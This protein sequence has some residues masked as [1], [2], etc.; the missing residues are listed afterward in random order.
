MKIFDIL[1]LITYYSVIFPSKL[2]ESNHPDA[3]RTIAERPN[4]PNNDWT[5][6]TTMRLR[7]SSRDRTVL[8][9]RSALK[10][11]EEKRKGRE[12]E[13][14][15]GGTVLHWK[16]NSPSAVAWCPR[17]PSAWRIEPPTRRLRA[18][19]VNWTEISTV[20]RLPDPQDPSAETSS[21][22]SLFFY[23]PREYPIIFY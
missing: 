3:T 18:T 19:H 10:S 4:R 8:V 11:G 1:I 22:L 14:P 15:V 23:C 6:M 7:R 13:E 17:D 12:A 20:H 9:K 16:I 21:S 5:V 2:L